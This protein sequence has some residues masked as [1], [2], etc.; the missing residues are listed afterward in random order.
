MEET[1]PQRS[2]YALVTLV[3]G[4]FDQGLVLGAP[5]SGRLRAASVM[6]GK[7][8]QSV[9]Q[10]GRPPVEGF[11][12]RTQVVWYQDARCAS[13]ESY[14]GIHSS[15]KMFYALRRNTGNKGVTG[16][17]QNRSKRLYRNNLAGFHI[18]VAH[19][20]AGKVNIHLPGRLVQHLEHCGRFHCYHIL[21]QMETELGQP[22][23]FRKVFAVF[24]PKKMCCHVRLF[25]LLLKMR[26]S[27]LE[28]LKA[29][30]A[31]GWIS[32]IEPMVQLGVL[33]LQ[34]TIDT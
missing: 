30:I 15:K 7:V 13:E 12:G 20:V 26:K 9:R 6:R 5:Y 25:K 32:A 28:V 27:F 4:I 18:D 23:T 22:V 29:L 16:A 17:W 2:V 1:V 3:H 31:I 33:Q 14:G 24:F 21:S 8:I 11:Y 34:E 10:T 19:P